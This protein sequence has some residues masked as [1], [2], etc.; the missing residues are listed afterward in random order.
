MTATAVRISCCVLMLA[1]VACARGPVRSGQPDGAPVTPNTGSGLYAPEIDDGGPP[2]PAD[3]SRIPEPVPRNEPLSR[4]GN[5][6][7]YTVLG[8]T[9][10][11]LPSAKGYRE[12]GIASWYGTKFHGRA[13]SSLEPYDM[14]QLSA[15]HKSL[16]LPSFARVTNLENGRS[17]TV[18][19]NDRGPFHG[20][21]LIDLSYAA[22][23]KLGVHIK[24]TAPVQVEAIDPD[25]YRAEPSPVPVPIVAEPGAAGRQAYLQ[26]GS[27]SE[28]DNARRVLHQLRAGGVEQSRMVRVR[29]SGRR[30]WRVRAGPIASASAER[31]LRERLRVLGFPYP[32]R[33]TR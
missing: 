3:V 21:R 5:R 4:Y 32:Q 23:V 19:V 29:V 10:Q 25:G 30:H 9:Y 31:S 17:V 22:A 33:V 27:Y 14:Y 24:G 11:V 13:T 28:R 16:P 2:I 12:R 1:L 18:R 8:Q 26:V 7:P 6:S 20:N 15:A